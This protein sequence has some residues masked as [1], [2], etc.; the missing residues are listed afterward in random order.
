MPVPVTKMSLQVVSRFARFA[1]L[2]RQLPFG[3]GDFPKFHDIGELA[4]DAE[5]LVHFGCR[6]GLNRAQLLRRSSVIFRERVRIAQT[7]LG[8]RMVGSL[9]QEACNI[10]VQ[11]SSKLS[12]S[13]EGCPPIRCACS[14]ADVVAGPSDGVHHAGCAPY[15]RGEGLL[16]HDEES[17]RAD[18]N[19]CFARLL[20]EGRSGSSP[21]CSPNQVRKCSSRNRCDSAYVCRALLESKHDVRRMAGAH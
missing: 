1:S 4:G 16:P 3:R 20:P 21:R 13:N 15:P 19:A 9:Y 12:S 17:M 5:R 14:P 7:H 6:T 2:Q 8:R 10:A 18:G 11:I